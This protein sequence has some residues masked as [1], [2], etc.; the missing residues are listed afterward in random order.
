M[1]LSFG[2]MGSLT[3]S[4]RN[5]HHATVPPGDMNTAEQINCIRESKLYIIAMWVPLLLCYVAAGAVS[6]TFLRYHINMFR[7]PIYY[8]FPVVL[9]VY[10]PLSITF[11]LPIDYVSHVSSKPIL[12]FEISDH[13]TLLMWKSNYWSTFALTWVILPFLQEFYRA[14]D[15]LKFDKIKTSLRRNL[16][17]Q[18]VVLASGIAGGIY[19]LLEAGLTLSS[20]RSMIISLSHIYALIL[21]L[22]LMAH[23]L[24]V[25]PRNRWLEGN[26]VQNL[27]H[28]YLKVPKLVDSLEDTK[29]SFKEDILQVLIL[30][31]NFTTASVEENLEFR[32]WILDLSGKIPAD[33]KSSVARLYVHDSSRTITRSQLTASFMKNLTSSFQNHMSKLLAYGS[34][35]DTLLSQI[36][37]LQTL[38]EAKSIGDPRS[39]VVIMSGMNDFLPPSANYY[40][41]CHIKPIIARIFA[42]FLFL[43]SVIIVQSEFFHS[44]RLSIVNMIIFKTGL[45]NHNLSQATFS[46]ILFLYMLFCSLNSLTRLKVFSMFHLVP[47]NSDPVS[48]C[49]YVSYIARLTIPLSYNFLTFFADRDS[50]FEEWYGK[51]IHLTGLFNLINSWAPRLLL[52][53]IVLTTFNVYDKVKQRL[54]LHSDLYGSWA[55]FDDEEQ[56]LNSSIHLGNIQNRRDHIIAEAKRTVA[57]E[58]NR[59]NN[60]SNANLRNFALRSAAD[61]V[62]ERNQG[63][64]NSNILSYESNRIDF[65]QEQF[66]N[67]LTNGNDGL[68]NRIGGAVNNLRSVVLSRF[69]GR[70]SSYR[71][72]PLNSQEYDDDADENLII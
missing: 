71:D 66:L 53:P 69:V 21:A 60:V 5:T 45:H 47:R 18:A 15:Y 16:K 32:D 3:A 36:G 30:E 6:L 29:I 8:V 13:T 28:Y 14:G 55:D 7:Y 27:N 52:I 31:S 2:S 19:L 22:W 54:G 59:R 33:L 61:S 72:I 51:S 41:Q 65:N 46:A 70:D 12:G 17:F 1:F 43:V 56:I 44:T 24:I 9:A 57:M 48:T 42:A 50:V 64:F 11:L 67:T 34:E 63:D 25:L 26:L 20:M 23:G 40:W 58:L 10:L 39:R 68:W 4:H 35:Y 38:L 37:R 62:C 49:F